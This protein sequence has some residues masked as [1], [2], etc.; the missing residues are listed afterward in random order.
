MSLEKRC[1][2][3]LDCD[4]GSDEHACEAFI[5]FSGYNKFHVPPPVGEELKLMINISLDIDEIIAID[6]HDGYFKIKMTLLRKWF[7]TQL[8]YQ[9]LKQ[10]VG[11]NEMSKDDIERMWKPF[12]VFENIE[13]ADE[14]K[15]T[16][17]P[18][19][20]MIIPNPEFKF[21]KDDRSNFRNTR[22]F[23]G[24][25]NVISYQ[26]QVAVNWVCRFD[27]KWYPFD[28]QTCKL[29]MFAPESSVTMNPMAVRYLGP[30]ELSQYFVEG[31]NICPIT[32][33]ERSGIVVEVILGRPLLGI[34]L[35]VFM[36]TSIL[37]ILSQMVRV[38]NKDHLEMVIEV[39]LTLL[40]VLATL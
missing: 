24:D 15:M 6:E 36:P 8:T 26:R 34:C 40:L 25:E 12:T 18:D 37:L 35:S 19:I 27:M 38:F 21:K 3:D 39:N 1:D 29:E 11:K 13:H 30:S 20:M 4:D 23:R 16:Q 32:I 22:L 5:T 14:E 31:V 9:N 17:Q 10:G 7:N 33:K 28:S 2:G